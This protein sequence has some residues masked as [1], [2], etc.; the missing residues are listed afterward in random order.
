LVWRSDGGSYFID[1]SAELFQEMLSRIV[2]NLKTCAP[3]KTQRNQP[4]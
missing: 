3:R 4:G 1:R 2:Q